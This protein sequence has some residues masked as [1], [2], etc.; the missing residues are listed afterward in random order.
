MVARVVPVEPFDLVVF[1]VT[2]DLAR[3]K[4]IPAL[5]HRMEDGQM[6]EG[7]RV[8]GAARSE[9]DAAA[10][11]AAASAALD[12]F[13]G[14]VDGAVRARFLGCLDYVRIDATTDEGWDRLG[15]APFG[16]PRPQP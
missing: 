13:V 16:Q 15:A 2:G 10:F 8:I 4:L 6:P 11:R 5:Y 3:R 7:A 9:M 1:G 12:E 14:K